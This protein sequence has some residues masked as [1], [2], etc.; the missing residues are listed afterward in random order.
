MNIVAADNTHGN[1]HGSHINVRQSLDECH[2]REQAAWEKNAGRLAAWTLRRMAN[3]RDA[4]GQ[5]LPIGER[6]ANRKAVTKTG[7][8]TKTL[9]ERHFQGRDVGDIVGLH[10]TSPDNRS[11]T[12]TIDIDH[13][14]KTDRARH[15]ANRKAAI[16]LYHRARD[17]GFTPLLVAT[18]GRGGYHLT[19]I[20]SEPAATE[21]VWRFGHW[22]I[23]DWEGLGLV[24]IPEVFPK[25]PRLGKKLKFGNWVRLPGRHH[26][27]PYFSKIWDGHRW[28]QGE[29]AIRHILQTG[30][31][32]PCM[33]PEKAR[34]CPSVT[35]KAPATKQDNA[36]RRRRTTRTLSTPGAGRPIDRVLERLD[37]V[38]RCGDQWSAR[39][40]AHNDHNNSLSI[41]E[42]NDGKVLLYCHAG[43]EWQDIVAEVGLPPSALFPQGRRARA[44]RRHR[45]VRGKDRRPMV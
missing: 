34:Q 3:R 4:W 25:Q 33:I 24:E 23:R 14:G 22:L 10:V 7:K 29:E 11:R 15:H 43:C 1:G 18:N 40:P 26:T 6:A 27:L 21:D 28:L 42:T 37:H 16:R 20:F 30:G 44:I 41:S 19:I 8:L 36:H 45:A 31:Q 17:L 39:C 32:A 38:Q 2:V 5:Y 35:K 9:L 13:H 12:L